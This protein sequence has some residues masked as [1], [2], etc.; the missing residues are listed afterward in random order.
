[1]LPTCL[2]SY[3]LRTK[4]RYFAL[5]LTL[6]NPHLASSTER[7]GAARHGASSNRH[8]RAPE[9]CRC[10]EH[11]LEPPSSERSPKAVRSASSWLAFSVHSLTPR[12]NPQ[13]PPNCRSAYPPLQAYY[14]PPDAR[15]TVIPPRPP[16][17]AA[18]AEL[19]S[20]HQPKSG[21]PHRRLPPQPSAPTSRAAAHRIQ[22]PSPP[23]NCPAH[24]PTSICFGASPAGSWSGQFGPERYSSSY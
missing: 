11:L 7:L 12:S 10:V 19:S 6:S 4:S 17:V 23:A 14:Q 1:M 24:S 9:D 3:P 2:R 21:A 13:A 8:P 15:N 22:L 5:H 20:P 18:Y 16:Q